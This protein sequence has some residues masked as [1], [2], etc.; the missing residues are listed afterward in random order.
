MTGVLQLGHARISRSSASSAIKTS[1]L[2]HVKNYNRKVT[3]EVHMQNWFLVVLMLCA[4]DTSAI[5]Q[6][7][8]AVS[9]AAGGAYYEFMMGLQLET[10]GDGPAAAAAYLR[11]ERLDPASAE[12]PAALAE[13]YARLNRPA[14]AIAAGERAIKANPTNP[15]ANWILGS[16][17]ARMSEMPNTREAD[18]RTY[19]ERAI[20]NLEKANRNAHPSVPTMLGRL[21]I[22]SGQYDKA[23][24]L[25][26]PFVEDQPD[27]I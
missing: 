2:C 1:P 19:A 13:L 21:Y 11:A 24:A 23:V 12:I 9:D 26:G 18:R 10:R 22:A 3:I 16:L 15:E 25:L 20:A 6:T 27:Q 17:Y 5:A 14:D 8:P 7:K 4:S